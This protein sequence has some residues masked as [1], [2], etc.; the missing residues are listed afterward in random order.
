[1]T[2]LS[3]VLRWAVWVTVLSCA[4][5]G[6]T[7]PPPQTPK[8]S[9]AAALAQQQRDYFEEYH[10]T[11]RRDCSR[12]CTLAAAVCTSSRRICEM[13]EGN[14][15]DDGLPAYC[16]LASDRC[17]RASRRLRAECRC[18]GTGPRVD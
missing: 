9:E 18:F 16:A 10:T 11:Q 14:P 17:D 3:R 7:L 13:A 4:H 15:Q 5:Q 2:R 12:R 6:P 1:M 8:Q